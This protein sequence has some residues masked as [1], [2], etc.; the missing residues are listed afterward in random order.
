MKNLPP[1]SRKQPGFG[2]Q[3]IEVLPQFTRWQK[4]SWC[5][6][7]S[8][9]LLH[10]EHQLPHWEWIVSFSNMGRGRLSNAEIKQCLQDFGAEDFE[11]DNHESG[12]ARKFWLAVD[13]QYRKP[14]PCKDE[15]IITEGEYQYSVKRGAT[16]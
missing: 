2:W 8:V 14:C 5:A 1:V 16:V 11:E 13:P 15:E 4:G 7:S 3:L 9:A 10:D 12:I 6:L